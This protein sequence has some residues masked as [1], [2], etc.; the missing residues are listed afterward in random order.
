[1]TY[2]VLFFTHLGSR[3]VFIAGITDHPDAS[4]MSQVASNAALEELGYLHGCR[5]VLQ[6]RDAKFC[7]EFRQTL[8]AGD[9][10]R[11][12]DHQS[13]AASVSA[14]FSSITTVG[15]HEFL[16]P[17]GIRDPVSQNTRMRRGTRFSMIE[18]EDQLKAIPLCD[19]LACQAAAL[20]AP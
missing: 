4:W 2:Y 18:I 17:S 3:R 11:A 14:V 15:P 12:G 20:T 9:W 1:M 7:A 8:A 5:Y 10:R 6:D 13:S 19:R 16:N